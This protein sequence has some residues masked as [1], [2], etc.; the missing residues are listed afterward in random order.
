ML[1]SAITLLAPNFI[2]PTCIVIP[3]VKSVDPDNVKIPPPLLIKDPLPV[4]DPS[5]TVTTPT[6]SV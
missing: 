5:V 6:E 2:V 4:I 3:P 1:L